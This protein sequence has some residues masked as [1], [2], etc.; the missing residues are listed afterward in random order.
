[1]RRVDWWLGVGLLVV[2]I[3]LHAAIPRYE[4]LNAPPSQSRVSDLPYAVDFY[5]TARFPTL[6]LLDRW[7]GV[8]HSGSLVDQLGVAPKWVWVRLDNSN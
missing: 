1:M 3:L 6:I 5:G 7:T 8:V 4:L 2:A